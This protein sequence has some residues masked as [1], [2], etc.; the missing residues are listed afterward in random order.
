MSE[1]K[2]LS[3]RSTNGFM[4]MAI[5]EAIFKS[6]IESD[7]RDIMI[8]FYD[9]EPACMSLGYFQSLERKVDKKNCEAYG[10]D[11][12]RR[13][14][15]GRAVLHDIELTYSVIAPSKLLGKNTI[16]SYLN[17]SRALNRGLNILGVSSTIAPAKKAKR[18]G[19][20][21]CFDSISSH[22][23]SVEGKKLVG[24]AQYRDHGY[25]LQ[26]G[27]ILIDLEV[28]KLFDCLRV[29]KKDKA[30][31]YFKKI[32]TTINGELNKKV[33]KD[34]VE[35]AM[36]K[37]FDDYFEMGITKIDFSNELLKQA[38][39]LYENKYST[40]EWNYLK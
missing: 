13:P 9:W 28:E 30:A 38:E 31:R 32:T 4:N 21:A 3:D 2:I 10:I 18:K 12:V 16:T 14:T 25:L 22:E 6:K 23:I 19:S 7:D 35:D 8:R 26:H 37:G 29:K 20:A 11:I 15:G 40:K 27:S 39:K 17:I 24:S 1:I 34:D 33:K 5:D 36:I